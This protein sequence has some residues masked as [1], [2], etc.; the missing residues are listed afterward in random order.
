VIWDWI[1]IV[2]CYLFAAFFLRLLGGF[3]SAA[4]AISGWG[5]RSSLK[6]VQRLRWVPPSYSDRGRTSSS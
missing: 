6:R 4:D 3:G 5:R 2:G 1:V